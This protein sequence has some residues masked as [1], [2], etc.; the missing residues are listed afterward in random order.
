[1]IEMRG[2]LRHITDEYLAIAFWNGPDPI[3]IAKPFTVTLV[4]IYPEHPAY[5]R[6]VPDADFTLREGEKIVGHGRVL[7]R[8]K[9]EN[10]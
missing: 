7:R 9:D 2:G 4:L 10:G 1:M 6:M 8:W 5:D 3:P